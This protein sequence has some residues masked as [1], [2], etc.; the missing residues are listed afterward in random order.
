MDLLARR[1]HTQREVIRKLSTK[2]DDHESLRDV[3]QQL[4]EESLISDE[5]FAETYTRY[6]SSKG[7]G[8]IRIAAELRE[9]GVSEQIISAHIQSSESRWYEL[10]CRVKIK[11]FGE[12]VVDDLKEKSKQMRFLINR[13][14]V[15]DQVTQ[16]V[17][18]TPE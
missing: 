17:E 9:R 15:R 6:R 13:G 5:R 11:K 14:F 16:A 10:A 8:P 18:Q 4:A 1:E 12:Q 7:F 2:V 3:V